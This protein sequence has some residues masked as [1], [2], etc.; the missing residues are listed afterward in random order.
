MYRGSVLTAVA[1]GLSVSL[2]PIAAYLLTW[3]AMFSQVYKVTRSIYWQNDVQVLCGT[4]ILEK[5][6]VDEESTF[7]GNTP[8]DKNSLQQTASSTT[9]S[10]YVRTSFLNCF[11]W[12]ESVCSEKKLC[13]WHLFQSAPPP[14]Y[15][16]ETTIKK[17]MKKRG[18]N[19][20]C[21]WLVLCFYH[22]KLAFANV[23]QNQCVTLFAAEV[24][25]ASIPPSV[26]SLYCLK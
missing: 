2:G 14:L 1:P 22:P 8:E 16:T 7:Y 18:Q 17:G 11:L 12:G 26:P 10:K 19:T 24:I 9:I 4:S 5:R 6:S 13:T 23:N 20:E 25:Q 21:C 15:H 3:S